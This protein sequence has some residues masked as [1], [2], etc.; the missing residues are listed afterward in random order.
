[1]YLP[2]QHSIPINPSPFRPPTTQTRTQPRAAQLIRTILRTSLELKV[3]FSFSVSLLMQALNTFRW[4]TAS[5]RLKREWVARSG[6]LWPQCL[7]QDSY[8]RLWE[9]PSSLIHL[10]T[11]FVFQDVTIDVLKLFG[12]DTV[13]L[14]QAA[15]LTKGVYFR[16][17]SREEMLVTLMVSLLLETRPKSSSP[18]I[19]SPP[20]LTLLPFPSPTTAFADHLPSLEISKTSTSASYQ[21]W[22]GFQSS[23]L[24]P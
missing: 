9:A 6:I 24:L 18:S 22:S 19:S 8:R 1:M 13:F 5:S 15:H 3:G 10:F 12:S 16:L 14:Q 23:L 2:L 21:W 4:W 20:G 11:T 17:G 7:I